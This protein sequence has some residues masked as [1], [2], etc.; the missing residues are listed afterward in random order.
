MSKDFFSSFKRKEKLVTKAIAMKES[1][2]KLVE[3][4][5]LFGSSKSRC[6]IPMK[7]LLKELIVANINGDREFKGTRDK[8]LN[9]IEENPV[10]E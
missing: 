8:W 4:Y 1:E 7:D 3:A 2:W 6:E 9:K 10:T 5:R